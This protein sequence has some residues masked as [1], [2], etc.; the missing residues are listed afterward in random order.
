MTENKQMNAEQ[1]I[2]FMKNMDNGERIEFLH[3]LS[4]THFHVGKPID[5]MILVVRN[6][7]EDY[8]DRYLTEEENTIMKLA[9]ED[10]YNVGVKIGMEKVLKGED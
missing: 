8:I 3:Y 9:Y 4:N 2:S 1:M 5:D 7:I 6:H 10:G